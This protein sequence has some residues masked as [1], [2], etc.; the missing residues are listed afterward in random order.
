[1]DFFRDF[2]NFLLYKPLFNLLILFYQYLPGRDLGIA[3]IF[4]TLLVKIFLYPLLA[5][6]TIIQ[7]SLNE[8]QPE[9][10][11]IQKK[12]EKDKQ[13]QALEIF[14][15]YKKKNINPFTGFL[16]SLIQIPILIAL[17]QVFWGG[18][19]AEKL[20]NLYSFVPNPGTINPNFFGSL[21]LNEPSLTIAILAG[22]AQFFQTK[23]LS[24]PSPKKPFQLEKPDFSQ[25][26]QKQALY[27]FPFFTVIILLGL[28]SAIGLYWL[29]TSFFSII[30]QYIILKKYDK[31]RSSQK[32]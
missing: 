32:N 28:P 5:K 19:K 11:E 1:M 24:P 3:I 29:A 20:T 8:I 7:K 14:A 18:L 27:F 4:L 30:Q 31:A 9:I 26:M 10:K 2:Y 6:A 17:F 16:I 25:L 22:L 15:L 12:Y 23:T 13:K 21:D